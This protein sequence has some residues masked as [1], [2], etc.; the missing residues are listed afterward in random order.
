[1]INRSRDALVSLGSYFDSSAVFLHSRDAS[2]TVK[3]VHVYIEN[4]TEKQC[5]P[6]KNTFNYNYVSDISYL[7]FP[8]SCCWLFLQHI[9]S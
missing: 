7:S 8:E 1:M 9:Y 4:T 3:R 2:A 5:K 6:I